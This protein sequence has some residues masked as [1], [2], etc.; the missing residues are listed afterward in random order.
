MLA[1]TLQVLGMFKKTGIEETT[2]G[3]VMTQHFEICRLKSIQAPS[4]S[5]VAAVRVCK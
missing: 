5:A 4:A 3:E 1:L 2:F